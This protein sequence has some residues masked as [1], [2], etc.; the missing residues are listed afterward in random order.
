MVSLLPSCPQT[1]C[2]KG[3]PSIPCQVLGDIPNM[4][5]LLPTCPRHSRVLGL[6]SGFLNESDEAEWSVDRRPVWERP[7]TNPGRLSVIHE[8]KMC[9]PEEAVVRI[10]VSML[11]PCPKHSHIPGIPSKAGE[12]PVDVVMKEAFSMFKSSATFPKHS[13]IQGLPSKNS[14]KEYDGCTEVS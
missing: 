13:K 7:L 8:H 3:F 2:L 10:M 12:R 14:P 4:I 5:N 11:P 6:P 9:F 1:A